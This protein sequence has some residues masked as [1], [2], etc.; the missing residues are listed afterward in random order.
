MTEPMVIRPLQ[1]RQIVLEPPKAQ[2][3]KLVLTWKQAS[4]SEKT[5]VW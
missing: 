2:L 5:E 1:H 3:T 4:G